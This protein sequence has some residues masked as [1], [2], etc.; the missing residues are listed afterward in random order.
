MPGQSMYTRLVQQLLNKYEILIS[1]AGALNTGAPLDVP[2][3]VLQHAC[4][5]GTAAASNS[6]ILPGSQDM[7]CSVTHVLYVQ[8]P[9]CF[10]LHRPPLSCLMA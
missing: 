1:N 5:T 6:F 3:G 4:D 10:C 9:D 8:I 2:T 7:P